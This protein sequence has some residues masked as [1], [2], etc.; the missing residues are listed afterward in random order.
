VIRSIRISW[1]K[2]Y[3]N[4]LRPSELLDV[5][6]RHL[7]FTWLHFSH[8]PN[9]W[10][11]YSRYIYRAHCAILARVWPSIPIT[12]VRTLVKSHQFWAGSNFEEVMRSFARACVAA[13]KP[14]ERRYMLVWQEH[15][16]MT[17]SMKFSESKLSLVNSHQLSSLS[18]LDPIT[19][20]RSFFVRYVTRAQ[21]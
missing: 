19:I 3:K 6:G 12:L 18:D 13:V 1:G 2:W 11:S 5:N 21:N 9:D 15:A 4:C 14:S 17:L 20:K 7:G 8:W 10:S 16:D